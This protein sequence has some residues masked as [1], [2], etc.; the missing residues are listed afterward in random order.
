M[1]PSDASLSAY[2]V[3]SMETAAFEIQ[4]SPLEVEETVAEQDPTFT[5]CPLHAN[6]CS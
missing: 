1:I 2:S 4:Y 5:I 6:T 3:V